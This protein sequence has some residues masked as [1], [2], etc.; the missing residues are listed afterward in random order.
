[1]ITK[2]Q[3]NFET[4]LAYCIENAPSQA[5]L[6]KML[7]FQQSYLTHNKS[8]VAGMATQVFKAYQGIRV[9]KGESPNKVD[10]T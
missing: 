6:D 5:L 10:L 7:E 2:E 9:F 1:M 8:M 4:Q 3:K